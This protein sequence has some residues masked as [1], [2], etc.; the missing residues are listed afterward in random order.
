MKNKNPSFKIFSY[1]G[2]W[3][4]LAPSLKDFLHFTRDL[5][6][7]K[8]K[9]FTFFVS[10]EITKEKKFLILSLI[11]KR[12]IFEIKILSYNYNKAFFLML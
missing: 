3:N 2:K 8:N 9:K 10:L 6:K 7:A 5:K 11:K 12:K 1:F 4:L